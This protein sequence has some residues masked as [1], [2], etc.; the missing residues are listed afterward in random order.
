MRK[1][2]LWARKS[3]DAVQGL[4]WPQWL[5]EQTDL[6]TGCSN[7]SPAA[8]TLECGQLF[9]NTA[10][11]WNHPGTLNTAQGPGCTQTRVGRNLWGGEWDPGVSVFLEGYPRVSSE[12]LHLRTTG[13]GERTW[14]PLSCTKPGFSSVK[15]DL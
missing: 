10:V 8:P 1:G 14:P 5:G 13:A 7:R 11:C 2:P 15:Q 9:S 3:E 4:T 12:H 6:A